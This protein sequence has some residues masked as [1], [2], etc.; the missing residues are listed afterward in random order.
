MVKE[1]EGEGRLETSASLEK[2]DSA[3]GSNLSDRLKHRI[4]IRVSIILSFFRVLMAVNFV[5]KQVGLRRGREMS[6]RKNLK[7]S[8]KPSKYILTKRDNFL[9]LFL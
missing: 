3:Q 6:A 4:H 1:R 8:A 5:A 9:I 7:Q 2:A